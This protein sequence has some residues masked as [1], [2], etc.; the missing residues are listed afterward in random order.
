MIDIRTHDTTAAA[1]GS[2]ELVQ[3]FLNLH[4]HGPEGEELPPT[5]EMV[6]TFLRDRGLLDPGTAFDQTDLDDALELRR[7][8][9]AAVRR[10]A[11]EEMPAADAEAIDRAADRAGLRPRLGDDRPELAPARGGV[12]GAL[13][14]I[15]GLAFLAQLDGSWDELKECAGQD[16]TAVFYDRSKNHSGRWCSMATCGN[17]AKVRAWRE[18]RRTDEPA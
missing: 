11:G 14:R 5:T 8:L 15:V 13:G 9:H 18:R 2:L 10:T 4:E 6:E 7:A 3:R 17:R 16:C 1:P 12:P